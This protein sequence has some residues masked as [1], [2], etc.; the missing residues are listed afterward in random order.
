MPLSRPVRLITAALA[1]ATLTLAGCASGTTGTTAEAAK[2]VAGGSLTYAVNT[3]PTCFDAHISPQDI[4]GEIDRNVVDSLVSEDSSGIFHPWLATSWTVAPNLESYT[5]QLR[6]GVTFTDGT[7]FNAAAVKANFDSIVAPA[8]QSQYASSLLG[9][10]TGTT[11][12]NNYEVKVSFS[13]PFAPFLQAASTAYL[14]FY[15]PKALAAHSD[16]LCA[17]G[18]SSV[19]TGPFVFSS[20][21]KGQSAVFTKNPN[22]DWGPANATHTG[23]AYL[24]QLTF[25]F[26]PDSATRVGSL[27]SGQAQVIRSVPAAQVKSLQETSGVTVQELEQP[28]GAYNLWLNTTVAPLN[29]Q[30]VREALQRGINI[31][32]DVNAVYFGVYQ[33]AW[34][35]LTPSTQGYDASLA[36]TWSYDPTLSNQLLDE[37]GWTGRNAQGY[38]TKDGKVLSIEWPLL[39][40][41]Y[42]TDQ[43]DVLGQAI[44]ADL[45]KIGVEITRPQY[46]I[47]TYLQR[48]Y[49]GKE[50][51]LDSSWSRDEPDVLW[52]FYNSASISAGGQN[53]TFYKDP[54]LDALTDAGR[55]TLNKTTRDQDYDQVQQDVINL[56]TTIPIYNP[57]TIVGSQNSVHGLTYDPNDWALFYGVWLAR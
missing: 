40:A 39:P 41:E 10:Y 17:G 16:N 32:A 5:F 19:G 8:T 22:Y 57:V 33:R 25:R 3:E 34:S 51:I 30:K 56:A 15:S 45:R 37:A 20:Y 38:R 26:L 9:P 35:P 18:A 28:G 49:A 44:Q 4:T 1:L 7:P 42:I 43:R 27:S 36:N 6:K 48:A 54:T 55:A 23:P 21:T 50:G 47:G 53:A 14:G 52:L 2:P 31:S 12:I 13:S 24:S 11:V 29:D 46:D